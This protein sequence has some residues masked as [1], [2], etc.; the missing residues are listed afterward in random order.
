V[1]V[2]LLDC[3]SMASGY[4]TNNHRHYDPSMSKRTRKAQVVT[5][6]CVNQDDELSKD[7]NSIH[8]SS[9]SSLTPEDELLKVSKGIHHLSP[10]S[11]DQE[12]EPLKVSNGIHHSSLTSPDQDDDLQIDSNGIHRS[13]L[14][15]LMNQGNGQE[16][17]ANTENDQDDDIGGEMRTTMSEDKSSLALVPMQGDGIAGVKKRGMVSRYVKVLR[18]LIKVKQESKKKSI[19][20]LLK[21]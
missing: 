7:S 16:K 20:L 12:D 13:S 3:R 14:K 4:E 10:S 11:L 6:V 15:E 8:S 2:L 17:V 9:V 19:V 5:K 1:L 21:P 18:H